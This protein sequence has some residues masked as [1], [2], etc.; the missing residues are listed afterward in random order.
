M[1]GASR[2]PFF[3]LSDAGFGDYYSMNEIQ[4]TKPLGRVIISL[5]AG[6]HGSNVTAFSFISSLRRR[7]R[8]AYT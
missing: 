1:A 7:E 5:T 8:L 4:P 6:R 3:S 2:R